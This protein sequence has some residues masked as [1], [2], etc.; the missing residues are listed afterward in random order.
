M[1]C[2]IRVFNWNWK[3]KVVD[4]NLEVL[5]VQQSINNL[6]LTSLD[7]SFIFMYLIT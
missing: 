3:L 1:V 4:E 2:R 6:V 5:E 7:L